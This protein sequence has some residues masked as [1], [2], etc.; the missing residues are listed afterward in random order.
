MNKQLKLEAFK[1]DIAK[2]ETYKII[3]NAHD[4]NLINEH[5]YIYL[6]KMKQSYLIKILSALDVIVNEGEEKC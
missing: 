6:M 2:M 4:S 5:D 3:D 1:R